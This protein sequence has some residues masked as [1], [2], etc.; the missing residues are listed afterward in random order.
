MVYLI[1]IILV[2]NLSGFYWLC[3]GMDSQT[4]SLELIMHNQS[5][6]TKAVDFHR[7]F[8]YCNKTP[9]G[10]KALVNNIIQLI[11]GVKLKCRN[12]EVSL[13]ANTIAGFGPMST[14]EAN[15]IAVNTFEDIQKQIKDELISLIAEN[16]KPIREPLPQEED[17]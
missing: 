5:E 11:D 6:L 14:Q 15:T 13:L 8:C 4:D 9:H 2:V 10:R 12:E 17:Y 16:T 1:I 3:K 7:F